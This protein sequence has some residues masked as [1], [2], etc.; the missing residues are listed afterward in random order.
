MPPLVSLHFPSS[1]WSK[2][3]LQEDHF[4]R[5]FEKPDPFP[6]ELC[7]FKGVLIATFLHPLSYHSAKGDHF[8]ISNQDAWLERNRLPENTL[9]SLV[10]W[11]ILSQRVTWWQTGTIQ[12]MDEGY[13]SPSHLVICQKK[14]KKGFDTSRREDFALFK[15]YFFNYPDCF[16]YLQK[17]NFLS[18][19]LSYFLQRKTEL[20]TGRWTFTTF[21]LNRESPNPNVQTPKE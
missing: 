21:C 12:L 10:P 3:L 14:G 1:P 4:C 8:L 19:S 17:F 11:W 9:S 13:F 18:L 6:A 7:I 2:H 16:W 5:S 15:K 20:Q